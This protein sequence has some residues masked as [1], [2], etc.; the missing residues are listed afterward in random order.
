MRVLAVDD[1]PIMRQRLA[2]AIGG[3]ADME[4]VAEAHDGREA[5]EA[6]RAHRQLRS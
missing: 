3:E 2:A 1:P 6:Y 5:V 4:L